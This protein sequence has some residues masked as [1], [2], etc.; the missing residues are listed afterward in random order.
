[1]SITQLTAPGD[2]RSEMMAEV[3]IGLTAYNKHL[4]SKYFY[5]ARGSQLFE[6]ITTLPEYYL[7]ASEIEILEEFTSPQIVLKHRLMKIC[8]FDESSQCLGFLPGIRREVDLR[9]GGDLDLADHDAVRSVGVDGMSLR[10][11]HDRTVTDVVADPQVSP[12]GFRESFEKRDHIFGPVE[13]ATWF[14]LEINVDAATGFVFECLQPCRQILQPLER[15]RV[16]VDRLSPADGDRRY[17]ERF[18][19]VRCEVGGDPGE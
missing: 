12:A 9:T 5:D 2:R 1:M 4:P 15:A 8:R 19:R 3:R 16:G 13:I 11:E 18:Q 7:T 17:R 14:R 6:Q 10:L